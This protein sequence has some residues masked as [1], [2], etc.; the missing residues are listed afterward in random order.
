MSTQISAITTIKTRIGELSFTHDF[1]NGYPTHETVEKIY[2]E[3]DF[4]RACQIYLWALP[5]VSFGE[6]EHVLMDAPAAA[7]GDIIRVDTVPAIKRFL[8]GNATTPYMMAWLNLETAGPYVFE[9]PAGPCAGFVNDLW[10]RPVTDIGFPGPDKGKGGKFLVLGPGQVEPQGTQGFIVRSTTFNNLWL[11]RLLSPDTREREA[12]LAKIRLYPLSQSANPPATKVISLGGGTSLANAPRG[13][14]YW[15]KLSRWIDEEPV[16]ERD[17]IMTGML[18][19]LGIEKGK[20]FSPDARM[21]KILTDATLVGEAMAKV[22]D[23]E[24]RYVTEA[25]YA[26]GSE[27]MF[28]LCLDPSQESANYTQLDART[29]WFYE[30]S[31]TSAGMVSKTPGVGSVYL[32]INKDND[33]HW[34]DGAN[35]YRLHVLPNPPVTQFWSVT[36]YDV[37]TRALIENNTEITD[38][39]S[40][41]DLVKNADGSV[42]LYFGPTAPKGFDKNWIPTLAGKA[43]F[44]YFR[45]YGPTEAHFD[46]RW[47]LP[48]IELVK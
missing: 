23:Y 27:W 30:A 43:W 33:G 41:Q 7:Y 18:K 29:S 2:E 45:L 38:R 36:L 22:N 9:M 44:P 35:T 10:Q 19:S 4:Q 42:D 46:R 12:M 37:A 14:H 40:R 3:R 31:C 26:D 15:E 28:E 8:T 21:K 47:I 48:N 25:L 16:Q 24:K 20:P 39:S 34:L 17:R 6:V 1:A 32:G 11:V 13:F 5:I